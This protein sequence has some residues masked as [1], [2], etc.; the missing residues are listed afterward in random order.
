MS[1]LPGGIEGNEGVLIANRA[2][3]VAQC[4]LALLLAYIRPDLVNLN[5]ATGQ[6]AHLL[7]HEPCAP[8]TDLD[9]K[10]ADRIAV[11]ACHPLR[12]TDRIASTKQLMSWTRR[13]SGTRFMGLP[14]S[15]CMQYD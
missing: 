11:N 10:P 2:R 13:A 4:H 5:A 12:A 7:V 6:L 15:L 8:V 14:V 3:I 1:D 9:E